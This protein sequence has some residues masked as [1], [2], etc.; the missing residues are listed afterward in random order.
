[1]KSPPDSPS[2]RIHAVTVLLER[3]S[4]GHL[5][6]LILVLLCLWKSFQPVTGE[7]V[8][9][10]MKSGQIIVTTGS[11]P[12]QD[13]FS[14]T[15]GTTPWI[16]HEWLFGVLFYLLHKVGGFNI[17]YALKALM[18]LAA[19]LL[20]IHIALKKTGGNLAAASL[21][22]IWLILVV[23]K[24]QSFDL[25][26]FIFTY[27]FLTITLFLLNEGYYEKRTRA[28]YFLIPLTLLWVNVHGGYILSYVVQLI[29]L[30]VALARYIVSK[31]NLDISEITHSLGIPDISVIAAAPVESAMKSSLLSGI[32]TFFLSLAAGLV[33]PY[34][35][36]IFLFPFSFWKQ[37]Y[38]REHIIEWRKPLY[39]T[40]DLIFTIT[41]IAIALLCIAFYKKLRLTDFLIVGAFSYLGFSAV[42][43][44]PLYALAVIPVLAVLLS[45]SG[46]IVST[47]IRIVIPWL[48][49]AQ[50]IA[51]ISLLIII[52]GTGAYYFPQIPYTH[53]NL[54]HQLLPVGGVEFLRMNRLHGNM[55]NAYEWGGYIIWNLYP[56]YKVMIDGRANTVYPEQLYKEHID[57]VW[58]SQGW[59]RILDKYKISF[60]ILNK[61]FREAK[62]QKLIERLRK[63]PRWFTIYEDDVEMIFVRNGQENREIIAKAIT[64][65]LVI[66]VTPFSLNNRA[67]QLLKDKKYD[68]AE[69]VLTRAL[70]LNPMYIQSL[71][72]MGCVKIFKG[73]RRG[74]E[75]YF[76]RALYYNAHANF[77]NFNLGKLYESEGNYRKARQHY[78]REL[79]VSPGYVPAIKG[80]QRVQS[81]Q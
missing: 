68:E 46:E 24:S 8:W 29:F 45:H 60:A 26:P 65:T 14:Y 52:I 73:D 79:Q 3:M 69:D 70:S 31:L 35:F 59:D 51:L 15:A 13:I 54:E 28:L 21:A 77:A 41:A 33:N 39:F 49:Q 22:G 53:L 25:R 58:G 20:N 64:G 5:L 43:H 11:I 42:R 19:F 18:L 63:D 32:I 36:E 74:A 4:I 16:Q 34:G 66:P 80:M 23:G 37:D 62:G 10:L 55:F 7:D 57:A 75:R 27:L 76:R 47:R 30:S 40:D 48:R 17:L 78:Q 72:N 81:R 9:H 6:F 50:K 38:Y 67:F 44:I 71:L 56:S 12:R 2:D 61:V 1:M